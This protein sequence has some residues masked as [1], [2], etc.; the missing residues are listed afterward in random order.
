MSPTGEGIN[1]SWWSHTIDSTLSKKEQTFD[2]SNPMDELQNYYV[3]PK[4][5]DTK[6][7]HV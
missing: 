1:R 3:E 7:L 4:K 5:P 6:K 2:I